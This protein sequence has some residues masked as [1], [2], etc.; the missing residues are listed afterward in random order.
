MINLRSESDQKA[1]IT[2][3]L[4]EGSVKKS[5]GKVVEGNANVILTTSK[6]ANRVSIEDIGKK[7]TI[8][9]QKGPNEHS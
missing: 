6:L 9:G 5:R 2:T 3:N 1:G 7:G 4:R 8:Y